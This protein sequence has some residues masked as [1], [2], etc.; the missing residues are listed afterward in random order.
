VGGVA[1][2]IFR[3]EES[4][5]ARLVSLDRVRTATLGLVL[6][7][8]VGHTL[9]PRT[10]T[11]DGSSIFLILVVSLLV[12]APT[13]TSAKLPGG[14]EFLFRQKIEAAEHLGSDAQKR[15]YQEGYTGGGSEWPELVEVPDELRETAVE[16]P[17]EAL[18]ELRRAL[19]IGLR[20]A[21]RGVVPDRMP[22]DSAPELIEFLE[23]SGHVWPEQLALMRVIWDVSNSSLLSGEVTAADALRVIAVADTLNNSFALGY[24]L[25]FNPNP[26][27]EAAGLICEYEHCIEHMPTPSVTREEDLRWREHIRTSMERGVYDDHLDRKRMFEKVL[28]EPIPDDLPD[29]VDHTGACPIFGHYCPGGEETV[30]TCGAAQEWVAQLP[31]GQS[32]G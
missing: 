6:T 26:D 11:L 20:N 16:R 3:R 22:P 10:V 32:T 7:L 18:A 12:L 13:L 14:T 24:S 30:R 19:V 9:L 25:N 23:K 8:L 15:L 21:A 2:R 31:D 17:A 5:R 1:R 4:G 28:A 27:W 29:K